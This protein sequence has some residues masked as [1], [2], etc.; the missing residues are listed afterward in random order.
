[1]SSDCLIGRGVPF[2]EMKVFWN[3]IETMVHN[4]VNVLNVTEL[5]VYS[6]MVKMLNF[7]LCVFNHKKEKKKKQAEFPC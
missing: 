3:E 7:M 1:M 5:Y 2:G 6:R 4:I